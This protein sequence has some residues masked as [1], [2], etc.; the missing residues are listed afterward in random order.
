MRYQHIFTNFHNIA[1]GDSVMALAEYK[2]LIPGTKGT[3]IKKHAKHLSVRWS[4]GV[5]DE[6]H[7][8]ELMYFIF[9]KEAVKAITE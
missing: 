8:G 1:K 5:V 7:Q 6:I 4:M 9:G 3:V 2:G